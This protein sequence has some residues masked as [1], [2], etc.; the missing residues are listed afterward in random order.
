MTGDGVNDAPALKRADIGIAMGITGTD[1]SKEA[2]DMVLLDDKFST[3]ISAIEEG[4]GIF[5]N[6]RKFVTY[7]LA[8]NI[9]EVFIVFFAVL[10]FRDVPL[11]ATMLLWINVITDGLPAVALGLDPSER[12]ILRY[13]PRVF[14]SEILTK[15][16]WIEM[17]LF[18]IFLTVLSLGI[19]AINLPEG[20]EEAKG[21]TFTAVVI[22]ELINLF[23]IRSTYKLPFFSNKWLFVS[24]VGSALLQLVLISV[25]VLASLFGVIH[26]DL[27]DWGY[28]F[29]GSIVL[30]ILFK[31]AHW[32]LDIL[33]IR[34]HS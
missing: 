14:Q 8:C 15:R 31:T 1:V 25:P 18:G 6:I 26:I 20:L 17:I 29:A 33:S 5:H 16:I 23:I 11:S 2:S 28:I 34:H 4:R 21:A 22:F 24:V 9:G 27:F 30:F 10:I 7:L 13:S 3:I 32:V 19:F 12:G